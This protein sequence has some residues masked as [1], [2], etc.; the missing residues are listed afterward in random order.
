MFVVDAGIEIFV[1][2]GNGTTPAERSQCM[3]Y[4]SDYLKHA[5]KPDTIPI[6][7]IKEGQVNFVFDGV[8]GADAPRPQSIAA[9]RES[10]SGPKLK[11]LVAADKQGQK[12]TGVPVNEPAAP[13][14]A[15]V[16]LKKA[17][18]APPKAAPNK[19]APKAAPA[20]A[21]AAAPVAASAA[22]ASASSGPAWASKQL[23]SSGEKKLW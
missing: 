17:G 2:V 11:D 18:D 7:R 3:K 10:S 15:S 9:R 23:K 1:W 8:F 16:P 6:T 21:P 22:S 14:F 13:K 19:A 20:P 12:I 5:N 4:A